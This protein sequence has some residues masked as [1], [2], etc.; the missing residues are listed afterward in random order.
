MVRL[1]SLCLSSNMTRDTIDKQPRFLRTMMVD[2]NC[3]ERERKNHSG[4]SQAR[5]AKC[6]RVKEK[7]VDTCACVCV[8]ACECVY[9]R[10]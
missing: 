9:K 2:L 10:V 1:T 3:D 4:D 8:R 7:Q 5:D 6:M